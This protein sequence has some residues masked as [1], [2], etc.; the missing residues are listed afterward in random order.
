M[1]PGCIIPFVCPNPLCGFYGKGEGKHIIKR[2]RNKK[3]YQQYLCRHCGC[4]FLE[5]MNSFFFNRRLTEA[6][7]IDIMEFLSKGNSIRFISRITGH[8]RDCLSNLLEIFALDSARVDLFL[9]NRLK[10]SRN[11]I[12]IFWN[13]VLIS[14][15]N[16][17]MDAQIGLK[18]AFERNIVCSDNTVHD[19]QSMSE[20]TGQ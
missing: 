6:D 18:K 11:D 20:C 19:N 3:G 2:G 4:I 5:T 7:I 15:K 9:F 16:M 8:D 12:V 13:T 17:H 1:R 14:R 10:K